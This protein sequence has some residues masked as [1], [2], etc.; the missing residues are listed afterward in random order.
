MVFVVIFSLI[1]S[2]CQLFRHQSVEEPLYRAR[3]IFQPGEYGSQCH[4]S[5]IIELANG[6]LLAAWWSGS[7]EGATDVVIKA[8]RLPL[9]ADS[10]ERAK[11]VAD[12]PGR[13]EGNP[14]LFSILNGRIWLFFVVIDPDAPGMVQIMFRESKD[15][16]YTWG[17][18]K[19]F[20]TKRGIRTRNHPI[21]M[22]NGEILL[23][24]FDH[25]TGQS[26]FLISSD[27]GQTWI[28]SKPIISDFENVQPSVIQRED[29]ELYALMRTWNEDATKRFLGQSVSKDYGR[30]WSAL[31]YS[32]VPT[33]SSSVEMITLKNGH[34]V[35]AFNDGKERERTPLNLALS[36][37]GGKTW[38]YNRILESGQ[39]SFSYPSLVQSKNGHIHVTYSYNRR[40]IKHVEVNEAWIK[41]GEV[42]IK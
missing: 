12:I 42:N 15:L 24:L 17:P 4:S 9:G 28:L 1:S 14:V 31:T 36:L 26:I 3:S 13:F 21:V 18:T 10:W 20:V 30:T 8:A 22:K 39:G 38:S 23:P 6:D 29:G 41:A 34:V 25:P 32:N 11:I 35:L 5:T 7:Y 27:L 2:S 19:E 33:V 40:F 16:G 37:D